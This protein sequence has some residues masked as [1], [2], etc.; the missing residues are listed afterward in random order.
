MR[1]ATRATKVVM[2]GGLIAAALMQVGCWVPWPPAVAMLVPPPSW[3]GGVAVA[4][5]PILMKHGPTARVVNTSDDPIVVRYWV[6][7]VDVR[8]PLGL[9][10]MRTDHE[11][12]VV[13]QP[14]EA[15]RTQLGRRQWPTSMS[16]AVVWVRVQRIDEIAEPAPGDFRIATVGDPAWLE[17]QRPGP[18]DLAVGD[19]EVMEEGAP[20]PLLVV[21]TDETIGQALPQTMWIEEHDGMFPVNWSPLGVR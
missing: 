21:G 18:Y 10:D 2:T 14:G 7:R 11:L 9:T 8:R 15:L 20:P 16:D 17:L 12:Q 6:A 3:G 1:R 13:I 19:G 5:G 4:N